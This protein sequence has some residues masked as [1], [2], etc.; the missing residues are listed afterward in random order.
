MEVSSPL[1]LLI[2]PTSALLISAHMQSYQAACN[3]GLLLICLFATQGALQ[4]STKHN[5]KVSTDSIQQHHLPG[6][7]SHIQQ[8]QVAYLTHDHFWPVLDMLPTRIAFLSI[9]SSHAYP[10]SGLS[11]QSS[12]LLQTSQICCQN[13]IATGCTSQCSLCALRRTHILS[14][15]W[16]DCDMRM[17]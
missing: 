6:I 9:R 4:G 7:S 14:D 11:L 2:S 8:Q 5:C 1:C 15:L 16:L 13:S 12:H 10:T 17:R 3:I